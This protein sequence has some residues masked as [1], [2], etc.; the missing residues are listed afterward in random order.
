M[1]KTDSALTNMRNSIEIL[2]QG[3]E[4]DRGVGNVL[5][6]YCS[7]TFIGNSHETPKYYKKL[8]E[9]DQKKRYKESLDIEMI[10]YLPIVKLD[11]GRYVIGTHEKEVKLVYG[12]PVVTTVGGYI[13][14]TE[15]L[16]HC[17]RSECVELKKLI[18]EGD[19]SYKGT[20]LNILSKHNTDKEALFR[21]EKICTTRMTDY[22]TRFMD[23]IE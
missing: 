10:T 1:S 11:Y 6:T 21:W 22:F 2:W 8:S 14:L 18:R 16:R 13:K 3:D 12:D 5:N 9:S 15:Y 19:R 17:A 23:E 4:I 20:V 7:H